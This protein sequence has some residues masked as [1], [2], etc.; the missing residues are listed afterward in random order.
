MNN[1]SK[2]ANML[3]QDVINETDINQP[4]FDPFKIAKQIGIQVKI[5]LDW[6]KFGYD[7]EIYLNEDK[8]PEIWINPEKHI[9]RQNFTLAHE[10]G[11]LVYDVLPE[12]DKFKDPIFDDYNTLKR[13]GR[14]H[15]KEYRANLFASQLLMPTESFNIEGNKLIKQYRS[16][17][18]EGVLMNA[19]D[20]IKVMAV[21]FNVS[22]DAVKWRMVALNWISQKRAEGIKF[23]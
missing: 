12:I 3:P 20:F 11:H 16:T 17:N 10:L 9:N 18:G 5:N 4:P 23:K 22:K 7:G 14:R 19:E 1:L 21:K 2:F 15:P 13:D 8:Q 6:E